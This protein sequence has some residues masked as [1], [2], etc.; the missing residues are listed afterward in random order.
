MFAYKYFYF[1]YYDQNIELKVFVAKYMISCILLCKWWTNHY[2][3]YGAYW[4]EGQG[5]I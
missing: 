5:V 4:F 2:C 1:L 3:I